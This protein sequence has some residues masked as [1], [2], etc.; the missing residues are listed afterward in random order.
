MK[1]NHKV[2]HLQRWTAHCINKEFKLYVPM[3]YNYFTQSDH[4]SHLSI[5]RIEGNSKT[6]YLTTKIEDV[7]CSQ[8]QWFDLSDDHIGRNLSGL[9]NF[10]SISS[11]I[12]LD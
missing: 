6:S 7:V 3:V 12:V 2:A 5:M 11:W 9:V 4:L 8:L 1:L 10:P